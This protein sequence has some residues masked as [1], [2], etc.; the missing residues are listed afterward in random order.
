MK[1]DIKKI[2]I[3]K[4]DY[5]YQIGGMGKYYDWYK[6]AG[7]IVKKYFN[8]LNESDE[9]VDYDYYIIFEEERHTSMIHIEYDPW[10]STYGDDK[11]HME[12]D[13]DIF[14]G[15]TDIHFISIYSSYEVENLLVMDDKCNI[16]EVSV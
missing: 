7:D 12:F 10:G 15:S 11:E 3:N 16:E 14:D 4:E 6:M 9:R 13:S 8:Y 1:I 5:I 2:Q